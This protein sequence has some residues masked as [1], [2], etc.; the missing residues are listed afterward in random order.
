MIDIEC[1]F[2]G[3]RDFKTFTVIEGDLSCQ[4]CLG[5]DLT[6]EVPRCGGPEKCKFC[7]EK[8]KSMSEKCPVGRIQIIEPYEISLAEKRVDE[9]FER[10]WAFDGLRI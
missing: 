3:K 9:A 4:E 10:N 8:M 7:K 6:P 1:F 5:L 2:C